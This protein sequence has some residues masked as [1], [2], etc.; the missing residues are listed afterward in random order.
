[1]FQLS[2]HLSGNAFDINPVIPDVNN[3]E[4][5]VATLPGYKQF[6]NNE[7]GLTIWHAEFAPS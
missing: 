6:L 2:L 7:G 1:V 3:I 4:A 5:T